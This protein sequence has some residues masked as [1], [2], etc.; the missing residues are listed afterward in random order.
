M[1]IRINAS[2][3]ANDI[4]ESIANSPDMRHDNY[5][6]LIEFI[7][8]IDEYVCDLQFAIALRDRFAEI[9]EMEGE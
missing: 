3:N 8:D 5:R 2:V 6:G 1:S 7:M 9:V 4:A